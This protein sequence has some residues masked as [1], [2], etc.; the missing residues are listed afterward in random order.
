MSSGQRTLQHAGDDADATMP[1]AAG[2]R[3][4]LVTRW[5]SAGHRVATNIKRRSLLTPSYTAED[6]GTRR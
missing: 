1:T 5:A 3:G 2:L 6:T 4:V